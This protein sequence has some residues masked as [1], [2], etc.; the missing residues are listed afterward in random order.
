M[1]QVFVPHHTQ[2]SILF[3]IWRHDF[4]VGHVLHCR[5]RIGLV[6]NSSGAAIF[7][8]CTH[9]WGVDD[10]VLAAKEDNRLSVTVAGEVFFPQDVFRP[11]ERAR[12]RMSDTGILGAEIPV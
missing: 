4:D 5:S 2:R 6:M 10:R 3:G 8:V 12:E 9:S 1:V 11:E 7:E